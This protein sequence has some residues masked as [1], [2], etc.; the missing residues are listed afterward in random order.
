M[1]TIFSHVQVQN[2]SKLGLRRKPPR[3]TPFV[4]HHIFY[5]KRRENAIGAL[6]NTDS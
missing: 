3:L 5:V 1:H 2:Q 4:S 6:N